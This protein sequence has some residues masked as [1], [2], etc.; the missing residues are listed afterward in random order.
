MFKRETSP[1]RLMVRSVSTHFW[2]LL[3]FHEVLLKLGVELAQVVPETEVV[4][5]IVCLKRI[6]ERRGALGRPAKMVN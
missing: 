5:G 2:V 6:R 3:A 1:G 4:S